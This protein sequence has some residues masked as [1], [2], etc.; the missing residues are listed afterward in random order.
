MR[1]EKDGNNHEITNICYICGFDMKEP[2]HPDDDCPCCD[3]HVNY[4][5]IDARPDSVIDRR[6]YWFEDN[7]YQYYD[8]LLTP[9]G[10]NKEM[11][12]KQVMDNVPKEFWETDPLFK[13][14]I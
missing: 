7:N 4:W 1:R 8:E 12:L 2:I 11:A 6:L 10:W 14:Y 13:N 5:S 9:K 3:I